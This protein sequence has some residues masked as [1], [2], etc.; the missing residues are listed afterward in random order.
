MAGVKRIEAK[1]IE[2]ENRTPDGEKRGRSREQNQRIPFP[3][4]LR[5]RFMADLNS[6][7]PSK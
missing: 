7:L 5:K 2:P 4:F 6:S 3:N 1:K